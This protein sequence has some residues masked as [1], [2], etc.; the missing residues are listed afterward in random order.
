MKA[1][2]LAIF[3]LL[4][5]VVAPA[6]QTCEQCMAECPHRTRDLKPCDRGCPGVCKAKDLVRIRK[7]AKCEACLNECPHPTRE[8]RPCDGG[9]KEECDRE[10]LYTLLKKTRQ[11]CAPTE[12]S[13]EAVLSQTRE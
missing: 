12:G 3:F 4:L 9:C 5:P 8:F 1:C 6:A 2:L 11:S 7:V 13:E 10:S